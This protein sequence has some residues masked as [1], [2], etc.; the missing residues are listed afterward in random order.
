MTVN[1]MIE[2]LTYFA[3]FEGKG[4]Y[5]VRITGKYDSEKDQFIGEDVTFL[6]S[7]AYEGEIRIV[8]E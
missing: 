7:H 6:L 4:D 5:P 1:Q 3:K 8:G 2:K